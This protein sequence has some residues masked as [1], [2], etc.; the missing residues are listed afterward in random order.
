MPD[1]SYGK[2]KQYVREQINKGKTLARNNAHV[3][4]LLNAARAGVKT[5]QAFNASVDLESHL[6]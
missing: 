2:E 6:Y 3:Q 4:T 5:V 1:D